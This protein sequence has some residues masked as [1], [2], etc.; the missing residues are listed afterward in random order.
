MKSSSIFRR[1]SGYALLLGL[2][3][4]NGCG[5][6]ELATPSK[7]ALAVGDFTG[8]ALQLTSGSN[9]VTAS[10]QKVFDQ[11]IDEDINA[12]HNDFFPRTAQY[13]VVS[14]RSTLADAGND[15]FVCGGGPDPFELLN[16][17]SAVAGRAGTELSAGDLAVGTYV[18]RFV[19]A[20]KVIARARFEIAP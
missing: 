17:V 4:Q 13:E 12:F 8:K 16:L 2:V 6:D 10:P 11:S 1:N 15:E 5:Q 19:N 9:C 20:G 18:L 3:L 14:G 7:A